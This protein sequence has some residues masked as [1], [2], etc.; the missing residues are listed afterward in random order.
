MQQSST[1]NDSPIELL[2]ARAHALCADILSAVP[3][4]SVR[5]VFLGGSAARGDVWAARVDG[6]WEIYS[7]LDVYL[8]VSG[9]G[10]M[11]PVRAQASAASERLPAAG[12]GARFLRGADVGVYTLEDLVAQPA[13]P[14]T[15]GLARE[16]FW[17][18]G[19][20]TLL[21]ALAPLEAR[22]IAPAEA[23]YLLENR[24]AELSWLATPADPAQ[25]RF[26]RVQALKARLD[27][28]AAHLIAEGGYASSVQGRVDAIRARTP[29]AMSARARADIEAAFADYGRL[30]GYVGAGGGSAEVARAVMLA[31][32]A[33]RALAA[34]VLGAGGDVV[35][36]VNRRCG[37]GRRWGNY[38]EF[39]RLRHASGVSRAQSAV[40]GLRFAS[41]SPRVALRT[42]PLVAELRRAEPGSAPGLA[43][44]ERY[45]E[46]LTTVLGFADG[47]VARRTAAAHR[48][49]S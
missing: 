1:L 40:R 45:V 5:A 39:V 22:R 12:V 17:L 47:S 35:A 31:A 9:P 41:F 38:R 24:I 36:Q 15:A 48:A 37:Q 43:A 26:A 20:R 25:E 30:D 27:I 34:R 11:A 33:W 44:L 16:S 18:F 3:A 10:A 29:A 8:V 7:D 19:D 32:D 13:R 14:G 4:G 49:I 6:D 42:H 28:A 23:L 46:R 2:R 21:D